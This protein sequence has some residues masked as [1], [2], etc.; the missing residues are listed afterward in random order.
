[1]IRGGGSL[2]SLQSFNSESLVRAVADFPVPVLCGIG[3]DADVP[4][5]CLAASGAYYS[6]PTAVAVAVSEPWRRTA[7]ELG[8]SSARLR[9]RLESLAASLRNGRVATV[10]F[11][12]VFRNFSSVL[13][14]RIEDRRA[15]LVTGFS[16]M[17]DAAAS[18]V[19]AA[20]SKPAEFHSA[21]VR[22]FERSAER[23]RSSLRVLR[24]R[25]ATSAVR[26][27]FHSSG[28]SERLRSAVRSAES[29]F[30]SA[31]AF[32][33]AHDPTRILALGYALVRDAAGK[34]VRSVSQVRSGDRLSLSLA[35]GSLAATVSETL[36]A[37]PSDSRSAEAGSSDPHPA[38]DAPVS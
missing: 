1:M 23:A 2:E 16:R 5:V 31:E 10:R 35:D 11:P 37:P 15:G 38:S 27:S 19:E 13:R 30:R 24:E 17:L 4:L 28:M 21:V 8:A 29:E 33:K 7:Q 3:H 32:L 22:D 9:L 36:P 12:N 6:T 20:S 18:T 14:T 25:S 34:V 26:I